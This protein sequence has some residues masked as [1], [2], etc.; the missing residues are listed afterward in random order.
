MICERC[1]RPFD[2]IAYRLL[3]LHCK[4]KADCCAGSPLPEEKRQ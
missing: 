2:P 4:H 3:C 1:E